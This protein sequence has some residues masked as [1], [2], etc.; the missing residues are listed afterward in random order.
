MFTIPKPAKQ[1][2]EDTII[3]LS[4]RLAS[5]TLLEDRRA[6][7]LGLKSFS[8]DYPATVSSNAL[9]GLIGCLDRDKQDVDITQA[10]LQTL[11]ILFNQNANSPEASEEIPL[12]LA[13]EFTQRQDNITL[14]LD[15]LDAND[16]YIRLYS[17]K[18][19]SAILSS[20]T[21]RIKECIAAAPLG[22]SKLVVILDD[23]RDAIRNEGLSLLTYLTPNSIELQKRIAFE[24]A[25][26][27]IFNII[28]QEGSLLNGGGL[29][30]DCLILFAN[31]LRLNESN[32]SLFRETGYVP[33]I[34]RLLGDAII[35]QS[36]EPELADWAKT[37]RNRNLYALLAV[38]RLF[39]VNGRAGTQTNQVSFWQHGVL[40]E[41][42]KL[43]FNSS[44]E[45][46]I[47]AEAL[48]TCADIIRGNS[49]LQ[50]GFAQMQVSSILEQPLAKGGET[51]KVYVID[52][53]LDLALSLSELLAFD[54]RLAACECLKSYFIG[55]VDIRKHFIRRAID[56]YTSGVDETANVLKIVIKPSD[57]QAR[58]DPYRLW[59]AS[60][61]LFHLVYDDTDVKATAMNV[62][63]GD[64]ENGEEVVTCLQTITG[65]LLDG[66]KMGA[67]ERVLIAYLMLLCGWLFEDP[68]GVNDFLGEG[69]H[70]QSLAHAVHTNTT[71]NL[72]VQ[73]LC[74]M[75]LGIIYEFST[76]DSPIARAVIHQ[77]ILSKLGRD[78][79]I[80]RLKKLRSH[81][82]IR[83]YEVL[84]QK[85]SSSVAGGLPEV[86]FD[87]TFVEFVKDNYSRVIR[88]IDRDPGYEVSVITNGVQ[89]GISREMVDSLQLQLEEKERLLQDCYKKMNE[90]ENN[91]N[92]EQNKHQS[93]K[94]ATGRE[95]S[96]AKYEI[97]SLQ[98]Q[99][100]NEINKILQNKNQ[101]IQ[102][103]QR[104]LDRVTVA[105]DKETKETRRLLDEKTKDFQDKIEELQAELGQVAKKN[106]AGKLQL[107][108]DQYK[109]LNEKTAVLIKSL[110]IKSESILSERNEALDEISILKNSLS[111]TKRER[112]SAQAELEDLLMV[113]ADMEEKLT[114]YKEKLKG[115]GESVSDVEDE[116][117]NKSN[118]S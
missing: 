101:S 26:D 77:I 82:L 14:L 10:I 117:D 49:S 24:D 3:T 28:E 66:I 115:L 64:A 69:S 65:N 16:F 45:N 12:W 37:Q 55:H 90:L 47:K 111:Q 59:F 110:E 70:L 44:S 118:A 18:L 15:F 53:L 113:F 114:I 38:L 56:G 79:Y 7:V 89:K 103:Y 4:G 100:E 102:D 19:L 43:A 34:S 57:S 96:Q 86:Y 92:Q 81:P 13:D 85:L 98:A 97:Q 33:K 41:A 40:Q 9:R 94:E 11:L 76:K 48:I 2:A 87:M 22:I 112:Q 75:L 51:S 6:A 78:Q 58:R 60:V 29:V 72:I 20:R 30:E 25:F 106:H 109:S 80:D 68:D 36:D 8:S 23:K 105:A 84:P 104:Q 32:Q 61:I 67:D 5:S 88:A 1:T 74:V 52:G 107:A 108:H 63:D 54:A 83:D 17:L 93:Y 91:L 21:E 71:D 116:A 27:R 73:G 31:L 99:H 46:T 62:T 39:L 50:E 42:L 35:E 95:I